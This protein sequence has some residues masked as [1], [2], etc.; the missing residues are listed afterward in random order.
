MPQASGVYVPNGSGGASH[1][2]LRIADLVLAVRSDDPDLRLGVDEATAAFLVPDEAADVAVH[3]LLGELSQEIQGERL[4]DSGSLWQLYQV[5]GRY[6]FR[7]AS[8]TSGPVP[9]KVAVFDPQFTTG[10]V[11]LHRPLH[12]GSTPAYPLEWPLDELVMLHLLAGGRGV[13]VHACGVVDT[14][15]NGTLFVGQSGAGKS[16]T[17]NLW[18]GREGVQIL[19]DDRIILCQDGDTT[20]MYGTPWHGEARLASP[21]RAPLA[22]V[23]F[24]K[25]GARNEIAPCTA[26]EAAA[27]LFTCSFVPFYHRSALEFTLAF[28]DRVARQ[29]PCC[30]LSF[31]PDA[32]AVEF[33]QSL[34]A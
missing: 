17:A 9:Y 34:N 30:E 23:C 4:F 11:T 3:A 22:R 5:G 1:L 18:R 7:F 26:P 12:C 28:Y 10:E 29:V 2:C 13:E 14:A 32:R 16:T 6:L 21:T 15:G 25:H 24:L 8:H 33:I 31:V 20:W 19:S 27:R